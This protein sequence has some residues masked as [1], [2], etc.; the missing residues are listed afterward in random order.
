MYRSYYQT[1]SI[2]DNIILPTDVIV[3]ILRLDT[4]LYQLSRI[5]S[6]SVRNGCLNDILQHEMRNPCIK[7]ETLI[8]KNCYAILEYKSHNSTDKTGYCE[9]TTINVIPV[10]DNNLYP[11]YSYKETYYSSHDGFII[12]SSSVF[13][14]VRITYDM[15]NI[16][17]STV[18]VDFLSYYKIML[19]RLL[20]YD[21]D[22][23]KLALSLTLD[24]FDEI[25]SCKDQRIYFMFLL[26]G[27]L[28]VLN[29]P[30]TQPLCEFENKRIINSLKGPVRDR[31]TKFNF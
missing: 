21:C 11:S 1:N 29:M 2:T 8:L 28:A 15:N 7:S 14:E 23:K 13:A 18:S 6:K 26:Y 3:K 30:L 27:T 31:I 20:Y 4:D 16:D 12:S 22:K 19:E 25:A 5:L 10:V 17:N 24:K 9:N